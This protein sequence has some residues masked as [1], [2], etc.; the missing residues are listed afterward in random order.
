MEFGKIAYVS[1]PFVLVGEG[2][3]LL[4]NASKVHQKSVIWITKWSSCV[5]LDLKN[6][7]QLTTLKTVERSSQNWPA[8]F[9]SSMAS[10]HKNG[11]GF[12][13]PQH[14]SCFEP[15]WTIKSLRFI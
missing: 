10:L 3:L 7:T 12:Q 8:K 6:P 11:F 5:F 14:F 2:F 9:H 4:F 15:V 13:I 1:G